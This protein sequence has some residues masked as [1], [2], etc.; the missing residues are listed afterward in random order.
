MRLSESLYTVKSIGDASF[1]VDDLNQIAGLSA[2]ENSCL[3]VG[4]HEGKKLERD[5]SGRMPRKS[6][7]PMTLSGQAVFID[8]DISTEL[9]NKVS[10]H[11]NFDESILLP[12]FSRIA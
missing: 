3:P 8:S 7:G 12:S 9:R 2:A 1:G 11:T 10:P 5:D 6:V 4:I